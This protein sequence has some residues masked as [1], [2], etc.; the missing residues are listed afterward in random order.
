MNKKTTFLC[1]LLTVFV[2]TLSSCK[3]K[4]EEEHLYDKPGVNVTN[5]Q[6]TLIIPRVS[7]ATKYVNVYRRDKQTDSIVN[8]GILYNPE[9]LENDGKNFCY[10][11]SLIKKNHTYDYRVR[12]CIG[13]EYYYSEWSD[14]ISIKPENAAYDENESLAYDANGTIL[15]YEKTDYTVKIH[16]TITEPA[17]TDFSDYKPMLIIKNSTSTQA[18]ELETIA[19]NTTIALRAMLPADF[20]DTDISIVGIVAQ[21][22]EFADNDTS[23]RDSE[24]IKRLVIW[25]EPTTFTISPASAATFSIPSQSGSN[26]L[27]YSRRAK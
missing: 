27:D 22:T 1:F 14:A 10:I 23:K 8:I 17:I 2:I 24:R 5:K 6:I 20:L 13:N 11:D 26:G 21:K 16:G 12:Y 9:A 3:L 4:I 15:I 18:F 25:T 7:D 19:D